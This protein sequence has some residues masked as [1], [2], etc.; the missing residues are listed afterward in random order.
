M[1]HQT[2]DCFGSRCG[3]WVT[4]GAAAEAVADA[5][6]CLENWHV[7]FS[8][9]R[10]SSELSRLNADPR[11]IV[12]VST[13]MTQ[14]LRAVLGAAEATGGLVDGTLLAE[15][16]AA[17][18]SGD[19][20]AP[21]PLPLAL[22]LAPPRR[23]AGAN[24]RAGWRD[25]SVDGWEVARPAGVGF[26]SGGLAK[27]LFADLLA[28][29]LSGHRSFAVDCGGDLRFAGPERTLE[30]ADPFGGPPLHAFAL[31][32]SAVAT[33]GIGRRSWIGPDGRPAHHLLDPATGAPAFTG[34]VQA[35]A[36]APTAVEAEWRAKAA[37]LG[38]P[39][40]ASGWLLHGGVVVLDDGS[41]FVVSRP[42]ITSEE[43]TMINKRGFRRVAV[44]A[45]VAALTGGAVA[46][47]GS[48]AATT[49]GTATQGTGQPPRGGRID[50][51]ALADT[52]GVT[53]AKLQAAMDKSRP[54]Q[55][56]AP[57]SGGDR[58]AAL[59]KELGL[60]ESKVQ[61]ALDTVM[62][63]GGPPAG[64]NGQAA[65]SSTPATGATSS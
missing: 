65:P 34:V 43:D 31:S 51:S 58:A 2:F 27:G 59:A 40:A 50:V 47:C 10:P 20:G 16:K 28:Q 11:E 5:R 12:P 1:S 25:V 4:G 45:S 64:G 36:L 38:G 24:P 46:G 14:L 19:L 57:G 18:Y 42:R 17:G 55:G 35:T 15:I 61:A 56:Q 39:G 6:R 41:H 7:R 21:V 29:R 62:P 23:P 22:R 63:R 60:S 33:S 32:E 54:Q 26:D 8:R 37:V 9:F 49:N 44:F 13:T 30:V 52:L 48:D 53:S 3:V